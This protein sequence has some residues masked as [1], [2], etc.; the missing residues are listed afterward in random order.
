MASSSPLVVMVVALFAAFC[1]IL[2]V[3]SIC[4]RQDLEIGMHIHCPKSRKFPIWE[5]DDYSRNRNK[6]KEPLMLCTTIHMEQRH[7]CFRFRS[8]L[9]HLLRIALVSS[10]SNLVHALVIKWNN[11][12]AYSSL[13]VVSCGV[14]DD[15]VSLF[16]LL[17]LLMNPK[18][19]TKWRSL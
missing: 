12:F 5:H 19:G 14:V 9:F 10:A 8:R 6:R 7:L 17:L 2:K 15:C 1:T 3:G 4:A 18:L 11:S 13:C 16:P